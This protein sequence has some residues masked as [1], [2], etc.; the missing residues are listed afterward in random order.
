MTVSFDHLKWLEPQNSSLTTACGRTVE[1]FDLKPDFDNTLVFTQWA[2]HFRNHYCLDSEIDTLRDGT[3]Y[4]RGKYLEEIKFPDISVNPGPGIR[5]GDFSEILVADFVEFLLQH[6]VPRTRYANK[7]VRNESTK[8]TDVISFKT[9]DPSKSSP[10]DILSLYEIKAQLSKGQPRA[11]LQDAIDDSIKDDLR[12]A[13]SL[14]AIKQRLL[15]KGQPIDAQKISRY[16]NLS[17]NPYTQKHGAVAVIDSSVLD[18][19]IITEATAANHPD[20]K[21]IALMVVIIDN[22]MKLV[23]H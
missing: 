4:T 21:S 6:W 8:G 17:G 19:T 11:R 18:L 3:G 10:K 13:E 12:K 9:S 1:V 7:A 5:S 14:N 20:G 16:Q 2:K 15:D 22:A 23:H